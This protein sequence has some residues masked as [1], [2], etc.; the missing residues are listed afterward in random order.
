[1]TFRVSKRDLDFYNVTSLPLADGSGYASAT[2]VSHELH[3][4]VRISSFFPLLFP[5]KIGRAMDISDWRHERLEKDKAM[6]IQRV[7]LSQAASG[8]WT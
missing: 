3:C 5:P 2:F 6:E 1:M 4:L 7:L 8:E